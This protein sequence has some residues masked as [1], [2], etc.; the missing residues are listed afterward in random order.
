MKKIL[1]LVFILNILAVNADVIPS[2]IN[3]IKKYG[4]GF[5][6]IKS[7]LVMYET[8]SKEGN[9]VEMLNFDYK[10]KISC[11]INRNRCEADEVFALYSQSKKIALLTTLDES[12]G[13]NFVCFNQLE[14]PVCGWVEGDKNKFYNWLDFFNIF[15][16]KYGL[17][18]FKDL[19]KS[20]KILYASPSRQTN[21][22]GTIT[23]AK[24]I[25]PWLVRGN[26]ILVKVIDIDNEQKTGWVN[27][28]DNEGKLKLFVKF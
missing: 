9:I 6:E 10:D 28:R 21:S 7:P 15:G 19:N 4:S 1:L 16:K 13:W 27:F 22:T 14:K 24:Y 23:L 20:D 2:Y 8:P 5:T 26:W 3:S 11:N 12:E 25:T 17:Y 18:L